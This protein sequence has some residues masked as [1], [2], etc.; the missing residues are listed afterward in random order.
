MKKYVFFLLIVIFA[1]IFLNHK[2]TKRDSLEKKKRE[3]K[4]DLVYPST[5]YKKLNTEINKYIDSKINDFENQ[6]NDITRTDYYL[7]GKYI[8]ENYKY[9]ISY[10]IFTE[11]FIGGA[12][13]IH[14]LFTINYDTENNEIITISTL[15]KYNN[16]ILDILSKETYNILSRNKLFKRDEI[17]EI[18]K[19]GTKPTENNFK[20]FLFTK[21]GLVI[22]FERYQIAPYYY[23]DYHVTIPYEK[24]L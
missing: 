11:S 23:G 19:E 6:L 15:I 10:A 13:P 16:K 5:D 3:N 12:H 7:S 18:L 22:Y 1:F 14:E 17:L 2:N 8:V 20:N 4:I 24:I 21:D 9:Y